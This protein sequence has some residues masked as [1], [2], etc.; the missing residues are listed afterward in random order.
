MRNDYTNLVYY[1]RAPLQ[2]LFIR[3]IHH[4]NS[5]SARHRETL[6]CFSSLHGRVAVKAALHTEVFFSCFKFHSQSDL[7]FQ[8]LFPL[9]RCLCCGLLR[10]FDLCMCVLCVSV[11]S[12]ASVCCKSC[13]EMHRMCTLSLFMRLS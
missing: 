4:F 12:S 5:C 13:T 3:I 6:F 7:G 9:W 8:R 2:G 10:L 1:C 11:L